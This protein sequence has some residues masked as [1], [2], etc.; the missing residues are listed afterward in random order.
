LLVGQV[1]AGFLDL[2]LGKADQQPLIEVAFLQRGIGAPEPVAVS[3][4]QREHDE[5][6][7]LGGEHSVL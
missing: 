6:Q 4:V 5:Q 2:P 7:W 3:V 1:K